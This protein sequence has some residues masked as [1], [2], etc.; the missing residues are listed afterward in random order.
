MQI[1]IC[2]QLSA[3]AEPA[4]ALMQKALAPAKAAQRGLHA[5][6]AATRASAAGPKTLDAPLP[7][8]KQIKASLRAED[9]PKGGN[10]VQPAKPPPLVFQLAV[11]D[12]AV[13]VPLH[14][15]CVPH[16]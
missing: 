3:E 5:A 9:S 8:P 7:H 15:T 13:V 2:A 6:V 1:L 14:S 12:A 11:S 10:I 16:A 4:V